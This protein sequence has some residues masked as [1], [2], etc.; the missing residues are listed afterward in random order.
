MEAAG[1]LP[2]VFVF[3]FW[4]WFWRALAL[5]LLIPPFC[6]GLFLISLVGVLLVALPS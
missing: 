2:P 4:L 6:A 3:E 1:A 5:N